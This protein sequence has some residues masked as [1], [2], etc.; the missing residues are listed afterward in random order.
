MR[1][2]LL[3]SVLCI[4]LSSISSAQ[5][6]LEYGDFI[7]W[8]NKIEWA[9]ETNNYLDLTPKMPKYNISD[10]YLKKLS[11]GGI[12]VY[13]QDSEGFAVTQSKLYRKGW[14]SDLSVDTINYILLFRERQNLS[15]DEVYASKAN[16]IC[17]SCSHAGL[18]DIIKTKQIVYY[19]NGKFSI[20]NVLLTP[21]CLKDSIANERELLTWYNLFNVAFNNKANPIPAKDMIHIGEITAWYDFSP[22][23]LNSSSRLLTT[24]NSR[25]MTLINRDFQKG[26]ITVYNPTTGKKINN[27]TYFTLSEETIEIPIYDS[28]GEQLGYKKIKPQLSLDSVSNFKITQDVYFDTKNEA[29]I[30]KVKKVTVQKKVIT[31][32]GVYLGLTDFAVINYEKPSSATGDRGLKQK[33]V[34]KK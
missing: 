16:C 6:K 26:L 5:N 7:Q 31:S 27:K 30:S 10:W 22:P 28:T 9:M 17:D 29:L 4:T 19:K 1:R 13:G 8:D 15:R 2:T 14:N 34:K 23:S 32:Y 18:F 25:I 20:S 12:N 11:K 24:K 21:M 3:L 33:P